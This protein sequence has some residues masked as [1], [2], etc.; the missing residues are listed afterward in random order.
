VNNSTVI[1]QNAVRAALRELERIV[2]G[3]GLPSG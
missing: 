3:G 2:A 1:N